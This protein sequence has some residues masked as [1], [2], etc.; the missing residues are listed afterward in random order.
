LAAFIRETCP[1]PPVLVFVMMK[2]KTIA[3]V[4]RV[5]FPEARKIILT[6]IPYE[7]AAAPEEI[8]AKAPAFEPKFVLEPDLRKALTLARR[9]AGPSGTVFVT[10]SLFLVGEVKKIRRKA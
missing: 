7:R 2:D 9:L 4:A 6:T 1:R 5:L 3:R 10:G 8:R